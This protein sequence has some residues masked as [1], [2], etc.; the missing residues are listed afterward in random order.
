MSNLENIKKINYFICATI[1]AHFFY[2]FLILE[3]AGGGKVDEEHI[4]NNFNL[5][6][7]YNVLEVDWTKYESTST[8][9]IYIFYNYIIDTSIYKNI[10]YFNF[11]VSFSTF[12]FFYACLTLIFKDSRRDENLLLACCLFLSPYFRT[13]TFFALEENFALLFCVIG[14]YFFFKLQE[15]FNYQSL[16]LTLLFLCLSIYSRS[17][18]VVIYIIISFSLLNFKNIF[19]KNN[20]FIFLLSAIFTIPGVYLLNEWGGLM[21]TG[22]TRIDIFDYNKI[23]RLL[24][25]VLIYLIPFFLL[26]FKKFFSSFSYKSL[27]FFIIFFL[28]YYFLFQDMPITYY[29]GG[30]INK[31][32]FLL[33]N[34]N[35][36]KFITILISYFSLFLLYFLFREKKNIILSFIFLSIAL[37]TNLSEVFQE[38]FDPI[39]LII[40]ILFG[41]FSY[42]QNIK[43]RYFLVIYFYLFLFSSLFYRYQIV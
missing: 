13:S 33:F 1:L 41:N 40:I 24:N 30:A 15:N 2:A 4:L 36:I 29:A 18:F 32:I 25:I 35:Y 42:L 12:F 10:I 22:G 9:L 16:I 14:F 23:P 5:L 3:N 38:Y 26:E 31:L 19:S 43:S 11:I 21:P 8:P 28:I 34:E 39:M 37:F 7:D 27:F 17:N 20:L 6:K